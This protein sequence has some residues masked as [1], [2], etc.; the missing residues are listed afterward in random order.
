MAD[1]EKPADSIRKAGTN[2]Q[3]SLTA[4]NIKPEAVH[5]LGKKGD[6]PVA[7]EEKEEK[8]TTPEKKPSPLKTIFEQVDSEDEHPLTKLWSS[9]INMMLD[10]SNLMDKLN[11]PKMLFNLASNAFKKNNDDPLAPAVT[12]PNQTSLDSNK[13]DETKDTPSP[14]ATTPNTNPTNNITPDKDVADGNKLTAIS[15]TQTQ[16]KLVDERSEE[17]IHLT[18]TKDEIK[19]AADIVEDLSLRGPN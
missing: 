1:L 13:P 4:V 7:E 8:N 9:F 6:A 15:D 19:K 14:L 16:T 5:D 18:E 10:D 17:T 3:P 12:T 2:T 11:L